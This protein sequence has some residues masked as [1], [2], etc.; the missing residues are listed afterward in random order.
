MQAWLN[1]DSK[2]ISYQHA[3]AIIENEQGH[4]L[5]L[6]DYSSADDFE[7]LNSKHI[8]TGTPYS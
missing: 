4:K 5:W 1:V 8:K 6:G 3:H 2:P 7:Y